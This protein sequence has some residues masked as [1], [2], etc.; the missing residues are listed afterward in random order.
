MLHGRE[1][2]EGPQADC[3]GQQER[4][5]FDE[6]GGQHQELRTFAPLGGRVVLQPAEVD[7]ADEVAAHVGQTPVTGGGAGNRGEGEF[8]GDGGGVGEGQQQPVTGGGEHQPVLG[9]GGRGLGEPFGE[10]FLEFAQRSPSGHGR[11]SMLRM[12]ARSAV[13]SMGLTR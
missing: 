12:A 2:L 8:V 4:R 1:G 7:H 10:P 13:S 6:A 5:V 9:T 3:L 11:H